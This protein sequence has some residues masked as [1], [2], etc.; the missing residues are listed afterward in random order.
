[1]GVRHAAKIDHVQ[2]IQTQIAEIVVDRLSQFPR[3]EGRDPRS[4][5]AAPGADLGDDDEVVGIGRERLADQPVGDVGAVEVAGINVIYSARD[6]LAQHRQRRV[7]ILG[8]TEHAGPRELHCAVAEPLHGAVAEGERA[9]LIEA[10]HYW[11]SLKTRRR[12]ALAA[13]VQTRALSR[14][15]Y[16]GKVAMLSGYND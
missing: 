15:V 9:G 16:P 12:V 3:R 1:M 13:R 4:V 2:H 5:L 6:G 8:C 11:V 14:T 7:V 10:G